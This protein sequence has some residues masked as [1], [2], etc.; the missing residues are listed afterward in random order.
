MSNMAQPNATQLTAQQ[1]RAA[2]M[3]AAGQR[4]SEV[5]ETLGV[6]RATLWRWRRLSGFQEQENVM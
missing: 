6:D 2:E 1:E 4:V 5:A 3:L